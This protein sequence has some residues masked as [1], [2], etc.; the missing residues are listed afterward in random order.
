M[1]ERNVLLKNVQHPFL[2]VSVIYVFELKMHVYIDCLVFSGHSLL[3]LVYAN[4]N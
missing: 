2:V 3:S 1:A 4:T